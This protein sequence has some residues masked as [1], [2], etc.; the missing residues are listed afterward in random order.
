MNMFCKLFTGILT[1]AI[2]VVAPL[3]TVSA[4]QTQQ[5]KQTQQKPRV[6]TIFDYKTELGLSDEQ[7]K[8]MKELLNNLN[9]DAKVKRAKLTIIDNDIKTLIEKDAQ[10]AL[11]KAKVNEA[12]A[13]QAEIRVADIETGRNINAVLTPMQLRK[14]QEIRA[15]AKK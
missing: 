2:L 8:R 3:Q 15:S 7:I 13:I 9:N 5:A 1:A 6:K 14:W 12:Y 11:I 10:M 4:Q